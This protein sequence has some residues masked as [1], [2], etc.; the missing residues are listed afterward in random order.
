MTTIYSGSKSDF[1]LRNYVIYLKKKN[2]NKLL[3]HHLAEMRLISTELK[4]D[5]SVVYQAEVKN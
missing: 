5:N 4:H 2:F 1:Y 3:Q